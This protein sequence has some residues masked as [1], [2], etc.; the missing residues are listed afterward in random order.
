MAKN[1]V[2]RPT[3]YKEEYCDLVDD[4]LKER[5]DEEVSVNKVKVKLPTIEG[6]ARYIDTPLSTLYDWKN[7]HEEFSES[8]EKIILEQKQRL[9]DMGLSGDY[10]STIAKLILSSNHG[11]TER[12]DITSKEET[13]KT[14]N[15]I[16]NSEHTSNTETD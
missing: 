14:I 9:L 8:L 1:P 6:Y 5:I 13:L 16:T 11:M 2:G 10:N 3:K 4:Y 12:T 7:E 15:V